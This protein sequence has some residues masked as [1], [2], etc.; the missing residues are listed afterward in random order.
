MPGN[1]GKWYPPTVMSAG[2][3]V[4][5]AQP[6]RGTNTR[7]K[8]NA[9][10]TDCANWICPRE[11]LLGYG[12]LVERS[13]VMMRSPVISKT[14][15]PIS[16][17]HEY[18]VLVRSSHRLAAERSVIQNP[19][20]REATS[21]A[22]VNQWINRVIPEYVCGIIYP[23]IGIDCNV[24]T[25]LF[26][27]LCLASCKAGRARLLCCNWGYWL[28][29]NRWNQLFMRLLNA[30]GALKR[31]ISQCIDDIDS[32][33]RAHLR[34]IDFASIFCGVL[35]WGNLRIAKTR[36]KNEVPKGRRMDFYCYSR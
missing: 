14:T 31:R 6:K 19:S 10:W 16:L 9:P 23:L 8:Y 5:P 24:L 27:R 1:A 4:T 22:A 11:I 28:G 20:T 15:K 25:K 32:F 29:S 17:C 34:W 26:R 36:C 30:L 33:I 12:G 18:R 3:A 21:S 35:N 7:S 13:L 2:N